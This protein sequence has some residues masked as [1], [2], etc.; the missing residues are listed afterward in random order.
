MEET[1]ARAN[2]LSFIQRNY[3]MALPLLFLGAFMLLVI[4]VPVPL[5]DFFVLTS[6][7]VAAV[8]LLT[9]MYV[10]KP[11]DFSIF[12]I[13]ILFTTIFRLLLNVVTTRSILLNA[14]AGHIIQT[15]AT[16]VIGGTA[17]GG[18]NPAHHLHNHRAC[19]LPGHHPR[20]AAHRRGGRTLHPGRDARQAAFH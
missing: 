5:I 13:L 12:P 4:P 19:Q 16:M 6:I 17:G 9:S 18:G 11:L 3:E 15:F 1:V 2:P 8:V 20:C 10:N 7:V 14:N